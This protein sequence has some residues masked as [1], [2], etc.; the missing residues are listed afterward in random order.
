MITRSCVLFLLIGL[1]SACGQ[2]RLVQTTG[3]IRQLM[4]GRD[5]AAALAT[6]RQSKGSA[7]KKEDQV[8]FWMD[9]GMLL[10]LVGQKKES[11]AV[12]ERA[13]ERSKELYTKSISKQIAATFSSDAV[14]DYPGEDYENVLLN[15]FKAF[16]Y[17]QLGELEGA[18]VEARKINEKLQLFN[19]RY[20]HKN[21]YN[22]DAFAHWL[23]GLLFEM[24]GSYDDARI[25]YHKAFELYRTDY[26]EFFG[27]KPPPFVAEDMVR[28]ALLS[29]A[30]D[31][32]QR[33]KQEHGEGL[34]A[35]AEAMKEGGELVLLH[36]NGE[37]P[38]KTD[39]VITCHF[40]RPDDWACDAEPGEEFVKK[41][42]IDI[43]ERATVVKL[44]IPQLITREPEND[45]V[46]LTVAG[47]T[48]RSRVVEPINQIA[49]KTL[50]DKMHRIWRDTIIRAIAKT[51]TSKTAGGAGKAVGG[52]LLGW[53]AEKG[54]S[55]A[56]Q[57]ME[58][59]DKRAWTTLPARIEVARLFLPP[60]THPLELRLQRGAQIKLK[61]VKI[62]KG[63]KTVITFK[64]V[65]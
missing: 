63:K 21:V 61:P 47:R 19:T 54:S 10:H 37:G 9:E 4:V 42:R 52:G 14:K 15:V 26:Q 41:V 28:A 5:Y 29:G 58:E 13:E 64:T 30:T 27:L 1:L 32:A 25:A 16:N 43:P 22:Q 62:E 6:L 2:G 3:R 18:L 49:Y 8:V 56:F 12:L 24:E 65:P 33:W 51:T 11:A 44:A 55:A 60:G 7:F 36:L 46:E 40:I 23:M 17:I 35:S 34:G 38:S 39:Y 59:A 53:A 57:A 48:A 50:A 45:F 31:E 20:E